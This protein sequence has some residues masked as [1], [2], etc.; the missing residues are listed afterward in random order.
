MPAKRAASHRGKAH[1]PD[2]KAQA[3]ALLLT[4]ASVAEVVT[5]LKV[6]QQTVTNWKLALT[7]AQLG[8]IGL[9]KGARVDDLVYGYLIAT[10]E[11]CLTLMKSVSD[12]SYIQKQSAADLAT[13]FGVVSDKGFRILDAAERARQLRDADGEQSRQ[14]TG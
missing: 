9:K 2:V 8:E 12:E 5:H 14:I 6:P 13:L 11:V 4:G 1:A 7:P 3:V 10:F